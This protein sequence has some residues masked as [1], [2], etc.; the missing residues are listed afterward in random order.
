[1]RMCFSQSPGKE[2]IYSGFGHFRGVSRSALIYVLS[3]HA[4]TVTSDKMYR[5]Q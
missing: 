5:R 4:A 3:G 1:M 2:H